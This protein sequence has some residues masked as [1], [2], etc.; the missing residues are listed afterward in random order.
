VGTAER[1]SQISVST[2]ST[3][4]ARVDFELRADPSFPKPLV[5]NS[6]CGAKWPKCDGF[7]VWLFQMQNKPRLQPYFVID[8]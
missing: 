4:S 3:S 8:A 7:E 6:F 5:A 2:I 1:K